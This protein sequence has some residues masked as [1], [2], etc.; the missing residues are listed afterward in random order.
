M[1]DLGLQQMF[2]QVNAYRQAMYTVGME[3]T[4][5]VLVLVGKQMLC[6]SPGVF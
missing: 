6:A 5:T 4:I 2:N 3:H 1:Y